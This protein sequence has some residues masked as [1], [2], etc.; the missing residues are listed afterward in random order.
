MQ[1]NKN[2][3]RRV[4][5]SWA[6]RVRTGNKKSFDYVKDYEVICRFKEILTRKGINKETQ[7]T[8]WPLQGMVLRQGGLVD[9]TLRS[10]DSAFKFAKALSE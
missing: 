4:E 7:K 5:L 6:G 8:N 10:K 1:E 9:F 3:A 2:V